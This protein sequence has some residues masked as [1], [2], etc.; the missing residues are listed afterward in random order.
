MNTRPILITAVLFLGGAC[1]TPAPRSTEAIQISET[2]SAY[3]LSVPV[4]QLAMTLPRG[5]WSRKDRSALGDGTRNP[6]YFYF[7]D[8]KEES[9]ILSG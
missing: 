2:K 8:E 4:S 1:S 6:R 5:D 3:Q 7:E 9:L